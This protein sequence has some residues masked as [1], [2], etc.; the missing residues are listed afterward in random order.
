MNSLLLLLLVFDKNQKFLST[1]IRHIQFR[2][3]PK[4]IMGSSHAG[5]PRTPKR[6]LSIPTFHLQITIRDPRDPKSNQSAFSLTSLYKPKPNPLRFSSR[7]KFSLVSP[8]ID[9]PSLTLQLWALRKRQ[10]RVAEA[11]PRPNPSPDLRRPASSSPLAASLVSSRKADT[12]NESVPVLL[13]IFPPFLNT[14]L[15]R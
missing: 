3:S 1:Q 2:L 9:F 4:L 15:L 5:N 14:L 6:Q 8:A 11:G 10:P 13:S 12:L 7:F